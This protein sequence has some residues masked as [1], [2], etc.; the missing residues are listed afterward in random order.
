MPERFK[1][2]LDHARRYTNARLY[3]LPLSVSDH[4]H[5]YHKQNIRLIIQYQRRS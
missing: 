3:L 5:Q 1:V 2:V 4:P